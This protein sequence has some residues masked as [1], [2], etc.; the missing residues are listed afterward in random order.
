[1]SLRTFC[2]PVETN[3][4]FASFSRQQLAGK[5]VIWRQV[6]TTL[7]SFMCVFTYIF[8]CA[9]SE[10]TG[11]TLS[12]IYFLG[13]LSTARMLNSSQSYWNCIAWRL[14]LFFWYV[15]FDHLTHQY[16]NFSELFTRFI[17][18]IFES[19]ICVAYKERNIGCG[20]EG[21]LDKSLT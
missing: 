8:E 9:S 10:H 15:P 2:T 13:F 1:M 4:A 17:P 12:M 3:D 20:F 21:R 6:S 19:K 18:S 14:I 7:K 5:P 16:K 11:L